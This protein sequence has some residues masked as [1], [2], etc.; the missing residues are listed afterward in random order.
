VPI[1]NGI[2]TKLEK[3][4]TQISYPA[5]AQRFCGHCRTLVTPTRRLLIL[6]QCPNC[7]HPI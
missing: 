7:N 2:S 5:I 1:K 6:K 3:A 4:M